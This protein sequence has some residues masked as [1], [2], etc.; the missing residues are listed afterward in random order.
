V[1]LVRIGLLL[2]AMEW[3]RTGVV[4]ALARHAAGAPFVRLALIMG[5]VALMTAAAS[6]VFRLSSLRAWY[7]P[8]PPPLQSA[9]E[10]KGGVA[11]G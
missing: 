2:G 5:G 8:I 9:G 4:L 6:L 1:L 7:D 11:P 3:L 10:E